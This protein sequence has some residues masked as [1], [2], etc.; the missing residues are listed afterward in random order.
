MRFAV[1]AF[2]PSSVVPIPLEVDADPTTPVGSLTAAMAEELG[3]PSQGPLFAGGS[4]LDPVQTLAGAGLYDGIALGLGGPAPDEATSPGLVEVRIVGGQDAGVTYRLAAGHYDVGSGQHSLIRTPGGSDIAASII[5]QASGAARV[6][7]RTTGVE[8]SGDPLAPGAEAA[9]DQGTLLSIDGL[10][11][12]VA[13]RTLRV[14]SVSVADDGLGREFNRPPRLRHT[15]PATRFRLPRKPGEPPR[16]A[17]PLLP[18]VLIPIVASLLTVVITGNWRF[19]LFGLLSPVAALLSRSGNRKSQ[20]QDHERRVTDYRE[21]TERIGEDISAAVLLEQR[22]L[23]SVHPDPAALLAMAATPTD[24]LWERRLSDIDFL[25]LRAG[26]GSVPS[27]ILVE[28]ANEDEHRRATSPRLAEVPVTV[29][30]QAAGVTGIAGGSDPACWLVAE[31]AVLHSPN[32]LDLYILTGGKPDSAPTWDWTRW[33]PHVRREGQPGAF[34]LGTTADSTARRVAELVQLVEA[35]QAART[36]AQDPATDENRILVVLD[37][38]RRLRFLPGIVTLLREG[39][40]VGVFFLCIDREAERLP[41]ECSVVLSVGEDGRGEVLGADGTAQTIRADAP[42]PAWYETVARSLAPLRAVGDSDGT[43]LPKAVRLV[44]LLGLSDSVADE[45]AGRWLL[46]ARSTQARLGVGLDGAFVVDL[47]RDGP[48]G[49]V[50]GTTGS[51]KS[52]LLQS[53]VASLAVANRPDEMNF[54]LVDYKGGSAFAECADLPHTVGMVTDLDTHLVERALT[55]LNSEL[56]RREHL[57]ADAGAKDLPDYLD[58]RSVDPSLPALPRLVI[59]IDEFASMVR[60]L[61]D[62]VSGMVNLAQR[63]RSLGLHLILAT[64]RPSGA[65]SA[66][67]RANTTLRIALRTTDASESRDIIDA[68]DS[69]TLS[70]STPGR[71][72]A[73]MSAAVLLP[74]QAA[75][76]GGRRASARP[77][78]AAAVAAAAV[79]R[80]PWAELGDGIPP[81]A[82]PAPG[83]GHPGASAGTARTGGAS[84]GTAGAGGASGGADPS[85]A[86]ELTT[87]MAFLAD[88]LTR[89]AGQLGIAPPSRPWLPPLPQRIELAGDTAA[90]SRGAGRT[91]ASLA[92]AVWGLIDD[93]QLQQQLPL[94]FDLD[95]MGH[96]H[97]IGAPQSGRSQALRTLA[98]AIATAVSTKDAHLYGIDCGTGALNALTDLPHVGAVIDHRSPERLGRLITRLTDELHS[99]QRMLGARG[100]SDLHELRSQLPEEER[101]PHLV[102]LVDRFEVFDREYANYDNGSLLERLTTILRDGTA[103]GLHLVLAGDRS[104]ASSRYAGTTEEKL[105]LR[106]NDSA[107]WSMVGIRPKAVPENMPPGRA[108]R[109]RDGGEVQIGVLPALQGTEEVSGAAQA[110]ALEQLGS[111]LRERDRNVPDGMRPRPLRAL[112]DRISYAEAGARAATALTPDRILVGLGGDDLVPLGPDLGDT[113]TFLVAGPPK[114]GRSTALLTMALEALR[115]GDG[116]VVIAPRRSPLRALEGHPGVAAV[117]VDPE[118]SSADLRQALSQ[119]PQERGMLIIDD[120]EMVLSNDFSADVQALAR[121]AAGEGWAVLAGG[122]AEALGNAIGGWVA[123]ARRNRQGLLLAPQS[124]ADGELIGVR[125]GRGVVGTPTTSGRGLL[126]LGDGQLIAVQVPETNAPTTPEPI[127]AFPPAGPAGTT[128]EDT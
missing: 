106:L 38:A 73:R 108:L 118:T 8:L 120:A 69:A 53:L 107:D 101:P 86:G 44:D 33:L 103:V 30:L 22:I 32:D 56:R 99:R 92:P 1:T 61:P 84:A 124:I 45:V 117:L 4:M 36:G 100:V 112:P 119:V 6:S 105:V 81:L 96:L 16:N 28:D 127:P 58:R 46:S 79:G 72:F 49:L 57:L 5:V 116:I 48:H 121:G 63:G 50:A 43:V 37:G 128:R 62:F 67:I 122:N 10:L 85:S 115:R 27:S 59:V 55:S 20:L 24:R 12:D 76:V 23:R 3:C 125:L 64:Q 34:H 7:A 75:R 31:A 19:I 42:R 110:L 54:V 80:V 114:S 93:P 66:D 126:H 41:E 21:T 91:D 97:L 25:V 39:P 74:F 68:P 82:P 78:G 15:P 2:Q 40:G 83:V 109:P 11:L 13:S 102:V 123:L 35:R 87:D 14:A 77:A 9:W 51:G 90:P 104:L 111:R 113:P 52:E 89:A 17:I 70:P 60:E 95:T 65:V 26:T 98:A 94:Q 88:A 71:A 29:D 47:E 18:L